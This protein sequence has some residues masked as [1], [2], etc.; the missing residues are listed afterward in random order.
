[1]RRAL[2][3]GMGLVLV[4]GVLTPVVTPMGVD[5]AWAASR[6]PLP[7]DFDGDGYADLAVGVIHEDLRGKRNAGAVQVLYGSAEGAT[8]RDQL[9][10]QG[11]KGVKGALENGDRFGTTLASADFD[12][13]GYA[14]LAV[15][16]PW[17]N[18]GGHRD[19]GAV[20]VLYGGPKG[21]TARDQVWHQGKKGVPGSNEADDLFG[22]ALA[23]GDFDGDGFADL[24]V[25]APNEDVGDARGAGDVVLLRG[26]R[27]GLTSAGAEKIRQGRAGL[28]SQPGQAEGF[29]WR[30]VAGDVNGDGPDDLVVLVHDETDPFPSSDALR[31]RAVH[32]LLGSRSGLVLS[33]SQFFGPTE[34]GLDPSF[35]GHMALSDFNGDGRADL[36]VSAQDR[37][38]GEVAVLHGKADG[39]HPAPLPAAAKPGVDA[40]WSLPDVVD[41]A[42][43]RSGALAYGDFTGDG[44]TELA[45]AV[46]EGMALI[47]GTGSGLG[48]EIVRWPVGNVDAVAGLALSGGTHDWLVVADS[49]A[50]VSSDRAAGKVSVLQGARSG[51]PAQITVWHQDSRG[52]K[53]ATQ[54]D[55]HFGY[56]VAGSS[57]LG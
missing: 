22:W 8:A 5:S 4:G 27:A 28:P 56:A 49:S 45:I 25:G 1:M 15:G 40:V 11:R 2:L 44:H 43:E 30:L 41:E 53:G 29:G 50:K 9:W 36:A 57:A 23:A 34:L 38:P 20:Q 31:G 39:L 48:T 33:G 32:L 14:D 6:A 16:I 26:S 10:H 24:A 21:L 19:A 12:G 18:V 47:R 51:K 52:I 35:F 55:D 7:F 17:E 54:R 3:V 13:D 37:W 46:T 42:H